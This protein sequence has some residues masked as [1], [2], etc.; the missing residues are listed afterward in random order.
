MRIG[1][2]KE[3]ISK[4]KSLW[5]ELLLNISRNL[6]ISNAKICVQWKQE[7]QKNISCLFFLSHPEKS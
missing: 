5:V 2:I 1:N 3:D 4:I 7:F 6:T